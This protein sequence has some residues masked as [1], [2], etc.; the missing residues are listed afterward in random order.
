MADYYGDGC[1]ILCQS[2]DDVELGHYTCGSEGQRVCSDGYRPPECVVKSQTCTTCGA[3]STL[4]NNCSV[5]NCTNPECTT[6]CG[7]FTDI[8]L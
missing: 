3:N 2:Q 8:S 5:L 4:N 1:D 6:K 7:K